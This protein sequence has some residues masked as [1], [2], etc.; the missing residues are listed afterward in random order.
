VRNFLLFAADSVKVTIISITSNSK[1]LLQKEICGNFEKYPKIPG[2]WNNLQP[3]HLDQQG[4]P[5]FLG[6]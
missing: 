3:P 5:L 1:S 2:K 4:K 6:G